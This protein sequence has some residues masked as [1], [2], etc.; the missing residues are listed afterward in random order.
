MNWWKRE[1][2]SDGFVSTVVWDRGGGGWDVCG[3]VGYHKL[4]VLRLYHSEI[5]FRFRTG[6]CVASR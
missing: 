2:L 6:K 5:I 3:Q 1:A 4:G